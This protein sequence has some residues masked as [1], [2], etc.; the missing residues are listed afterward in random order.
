MPMG[1]GSVPSGRALPPGRSCF[2]DPKEQ[3]KPFVL[4]EQHR[5]IYDSLA[6]PQ[7]TGGPMFHRY[8]DEAGLRLRHL[9]A[10]D[11]RYK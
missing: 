3:V 11:L 8:F 6:P 10:A 2:G 7:A 4:H 5:D 9:A 1:K